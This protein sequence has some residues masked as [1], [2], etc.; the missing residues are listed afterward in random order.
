MGGLR[1]W[2]AAAA[3]LVMAGFF[4]LPRARG[5]PVPFVPRDLRDRTLAA[6]AVDLAF[7]AM[8][9]SHDSVFAVARAL[10]RTHRSARCL[11][12][13]STNL[14]VADCGHLDIATAERVPIVYSTD[15]AARRIVGVGT[16]RAIA[17]AHAPAPRCRARHDAGICCRRIV[18]GCEHSVAAS[19]AGAALRRAPMELHGGAG[20]PQRGPLLLNRVCGR[21][22]VRRAFLRRRRIRPVPR[23][24]ASS[25]KHGTSSRNFAVHLRRGR[26]PYCPW[27]YALLLLC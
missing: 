24:G 2:R 7:Q 12:G 9:R 10:R 20:W 18:L 19:L 13:T 17:P 16:H 4:K 22:R 6:G 5:A 1:P 23:T 25:S 14:V 27:P 8:A 21:R 11:G 15:F 3:I 26:S